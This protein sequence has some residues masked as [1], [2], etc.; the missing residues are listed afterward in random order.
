MNIT[1]TYTRKPKN[2]C[3]SLYC[4][5]CL[6]VVVWKQ[7]WNI[8]KVCLYTR[9]PPSLAS[10]ITAQWAREQSSHSREQDHIW[11]QQYGLVLT[12][13]D[14]AAATSQYPICQ[15]QRSALS[16]QYGIIPQGEQPATWWQTDYNELLPSWK[17]KSFTLTD[18]YSGYCS[19]FTASSAS[20]K[21]TTHPLWALPPSASMSKEGKSNIRYINNS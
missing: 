19:A 10:P 13:A 15:L 21:P 5:M 3:D 11:V 9:Q 20:A 12:M 14:M 17:G 6:M 16:A 2:S 8:P 4:N 18:R 1:F 7:T